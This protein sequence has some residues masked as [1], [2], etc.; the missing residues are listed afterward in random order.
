M[1]KQHSQ[2]RINKK[3]ILV[4]NASKTTS[5]FLGWSFA[6]VFIALIGFIIYA[7]I[8]GFKHFGIANIIFT[9][10]FDLTNGKA[11]V[12]LPLCVT[13][14]SSGLA[15]LIAGPIGIKS[16]I[17][18]KYR[19]SV[20]YQKWFRIAI[21]V[22]AD[23]PSVIFGLF[24][25]QVLSQIT[26]TVLGPGTSYSTITA[27]IMLSFMILPTIVS[28]SLNA[29]DGVDHAL[30]SSA[31]AL[32]NTKTKAI[33]KICKRDC[34][35]GITVGVIIAI[36]RAI[37]ETM[38]VSMILQS[39][40][41]NQEFNNGIWSVLTSGL[42]SL[43]A[44]ISANM[45]A[46][47]GGEWLQGLLFAFGIVMFIFVIIL[48]AIA[49][50]LTKKKVNQRYTWWN[51]L[52]RDITNVVFVIP[53]SIKT[54][55]E[56]ITY[57]HQVSQDNLAQFIARRVQKNKFLKL[58][59]YWKRFWEFFA[60]GLTFVFLFFI[61]ENVLVRGGVA[62]HS[63]YA[64]A[65][66]FIKDTTGQ[67]FINTVLIILVAIGIGFPISLMIAIYLNEFAGQSKV[68][69]VLLFFIDSLG[70][71]PSIL[72]GMFGLIFFVQTLGITSQGTAGKSLIAGALTILIVIL[73]IF[74]RTI[75]Q[76][77]QAVPE[78]YR[79]NSYALGASK[80]ETITKIVLPL[81]RQ[82][83]MT[84]LVLSIGR[85]LA[86]TAPLYLTSGLASGSHISFSSEGQTLT[87]RIYA[88]IYE[89]DV[90]KS[91]SIMYE[92]AFVTMIL[93]LIIILIVHVFIP[94]YFKHKERSDQKRHD[95]IASIAKK[96]Q[97]QNNEKH[98]HN[99]KSLII[100]KLNYLKSIGLQERYLFNYYS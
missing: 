68:K 17:F 22:L 8:P 44:L 81:A 60:I 14:L 70:A 24:A 42:R 82:G 13:I 35:N 50:K 45:F 39:Q 19:M 7:S 92:C 84:S 76:A 9:G 77:L 12:W 3:K 11:S 88:Q 71:T 15:I 36:S 21:E 79:T 61:L 2:K 32:G 85:I 18:I 27:S 1:A 75:Q 53:D 5:S 23:I 64:S 6:L 28:L 62:L 73:P 54:L 91:Q 83:I 4:D 94:W 97:E 74:I 86:E 30:L 67:A 63:Q 48:N 95:L 66:S 33:Y 47:G 51:N 80:W 58:Y 46:E 57:N 10:D 25:S 89:A 38:A 41:Y 78:E 16:S 40:L 59:D 90:A 20:K 65:I 52:A 69:K 72:F 93:V 56:K 26:Q 99:F 55:Y 31:M 43:G 96:K 49:M 29:L 37:G 98:K 87:T 34:R 100:N